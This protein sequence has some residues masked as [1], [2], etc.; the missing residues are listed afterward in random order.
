MIMGSSSDLIRSGDLPKALTRASGAPSGAKLG[1]ARA[2][3]QFKVQLILDALQQARGCFTEAAAILGVHPNYLH[4][5][6]TAL[7]LRGVARKQVVA[8][9][10]LRFARG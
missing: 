1:Y 7:D 10:P 9:I 5:L 3:Q 4:R 6:V 2:V 8:E